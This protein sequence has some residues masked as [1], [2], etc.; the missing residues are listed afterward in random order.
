MK[1]NIQF[2][3]IIF[4]LFAFSCKETNNSKITESIALPYY[5]DAY[6]TPVW[7]NK[8]SVELANFHKI[9]NFELISHRG[10]IITEKTVEGKIYVTNFFFTTCPGI[11]PKMTS[12]LSILQDEFKNDTTLLLL[13]H[14]VTPD[15]DS[16]AVL[17]KFAQKNNVS[18]NQWHL[19]TGKRQQIYNLG[20]LFYFVEEDL[21]MEK[22]PDD[23]LHTENFVLIDKNRH[24][25]GIYNGLNTTAVNQLIA[26]I[27]TLKTE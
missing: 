15:K 5:K 6:F 1:N 21:G 26:D 9:P 16:V 18:A 14:S 25:R 3:L 7:L 11:C 22:D 8:N 20:R 13:S 27:Y 19:L 24:I 23:F 10:E 4:I 12:N 2:S 17:A